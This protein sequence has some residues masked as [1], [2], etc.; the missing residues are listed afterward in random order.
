MGRGRGAGSWER[1]AFFK[2]GAQTL[3]K[4]FIFLFIQVTNEGYLSVLSGIL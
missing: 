2:D 3:L 4:V 1:G